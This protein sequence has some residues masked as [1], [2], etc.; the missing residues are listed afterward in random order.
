MVDKN[1]V[2]WRLQRLKKHF[3]EAIQKFIKW[4]L[5]YLYGGPCNYG[6]YFQEMASNIC[7]LCRRCNTMQRQILNTVK[8]LKWS[9]LLKT[10]NYVCKT[11][12]LRS[13]T[14]FWIP[15]EMK[16]SFQLVSEM[17]L[18]VLISIKIFIQYM[19]YLKRLPWWKWNLFRTK[20][21][22]SFLSFEPYMLMCLSCFLSYV[23]LTMRIW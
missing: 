9:V 5:V 19:F 13:L 11:F 10:V 7:I 18:T 4:C 3:S 20:M 2:Y 16:Q 1:V 6:N 12:Y 22:L 23:A 8:Q 21:A 14:W 15:S 17:I